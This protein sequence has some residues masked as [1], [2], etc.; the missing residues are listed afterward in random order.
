MEEGVVEIGGRRAPP[1]IRLTRRLHPGTD[2]AQ[3]IRAS[4]TDEIGRSAADGRWPL[5]RRHGGG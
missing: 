1:D 3:S 4:V 5:R 2:G